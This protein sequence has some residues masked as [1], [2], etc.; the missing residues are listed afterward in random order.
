MNRKNVVKTRIGG[1]GDE[2]SVQPQQAM[3][4]VQNTLQANDDR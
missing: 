2:G 1:R 3:F 4:N